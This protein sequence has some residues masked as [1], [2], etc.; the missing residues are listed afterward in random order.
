MVAIPIVA[1]ATSTSPF[2]STVIGFD[3]SPRVSTFCTSLPK[4][5]YMPSASACHTSTTAFSS[6][7]QAV[8]MGDA[9]ATLTMSLSLVPLRPS[10][11]SRR[12]GD[13]S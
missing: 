3:K 10:V 6:G 9:F 2:R 8:P 1:S 7:A 5:E 13:D 4:F 11:M 12:R